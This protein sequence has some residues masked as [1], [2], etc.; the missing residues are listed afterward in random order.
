[1]PETAARTSSNACDHM[2]VAL[3]QCTDK[4]LTDCARSGGLPCSEREASGGSECHLCSRRRSATSANKVSLTVARAHCGTHKCMMGVD[5]HQVRNAYRHAP[6]DVR[7]CLQEFMHSHMH[8]YVHA[9]ARMCIHT[10][11]IPAMRP[12]GRGTC[13]RRGLFSRCSSLQV[14]SCSGASLARSASGAPRELEL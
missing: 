3:P 4:T 12:S 10:P 14:H 7:A 11:P 6:I 13:S 8:R 2:G 5:I 1:M 9:C